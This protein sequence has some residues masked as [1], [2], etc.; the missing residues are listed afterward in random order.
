MLK[1]A[2]ITAELHAKFPTQSI[3]TFERFVVQNLQETSLKFQRTI[4]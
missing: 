2:D 3:E 4:K 1:V